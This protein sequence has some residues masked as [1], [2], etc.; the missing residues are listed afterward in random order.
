[1]PSFFQDWDQ[2][3]EAFGEKGMKKLWSTANIRAAGSG[4]SD[5]AFLPFLSQL[6]GDHDVTRRTTST[7]KTGRSVSTAIQRQ[8]LMDVNDLAALPRG[9]AVLSRRDCPRP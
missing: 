8:R 9:R 2:D 4:L 3:L 1:L 6:I 7:Q 5:S